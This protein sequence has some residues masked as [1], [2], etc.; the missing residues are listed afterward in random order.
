MGTPHVGNVVEGTGGLRKLRFGRTARGIG[1]RGGVR[2]CYVYFARHATVFLVTVYGKNEKDDLTASEKGLFREL[3]Q[4]MEL[5]FD[6]RT[7]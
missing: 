3:I 6:R 7:K 1:K 2:V 4:R 5:E